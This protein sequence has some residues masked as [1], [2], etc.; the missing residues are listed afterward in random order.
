MWAWSLYLIPKKKS[1]AGPV[2][3]PK[4]T[5]SLFLFS[6]SLYVSVL[7]HIYRNI[8]DITHMYKDKTNLFWMSLCPCRYWCRDVML[9]SSQWHDH[10]VMSFNAVSVKKQ[11][12]EERRTVH[13]AGVISVSLIFWPDFFHL[14]V[15]C[16]L[17]PSGSGILNSYI[18]RNSNNYCNV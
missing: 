7:R 3:K 2:L 8:M 17:N 1:M 9:P 16:W 6:Q 15:F 18:N 4:K 14:S 12:D 10:V 13:T 11:I 5:Q